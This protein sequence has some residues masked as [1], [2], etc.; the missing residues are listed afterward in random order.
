M[1]K[2]LSRILIPS[3]FPI[4]VF[5]L[6]EYLI[7]KLIYFRILLFCIFIKTSKRTTV[8]YYSKLRTKRTSTTTCIVILK[9]VWFL[10]T[11]FTKFYFMKPYKIWIRFIFKAIL[12]KLHFIVIILFYWLYAFINLYFIKSY[13]LCPLWFIWFSICF[14]FRMPFMMWHEVFI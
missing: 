14:V 11:V 4:T 5:S 8:N 7:R 1:F 12:L 6:F 3:D 13:F 9:L 2:L 10:I